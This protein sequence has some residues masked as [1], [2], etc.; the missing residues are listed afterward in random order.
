MKKV[1]VKLKLIGVEQRLETT[2]YAVKLE[3]F[4]EFEFAATR[5]LIASKPGVFSDTYWQVV[6]VASGKGISTGYPTIKAAV[7]AAES[8]LLRMAAD[9]SMAA[10]KA[11]LSAG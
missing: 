10:V 11:R 6:E 9:S 2:G 4:G 1:P 3:F 8:R 5:A 7:A